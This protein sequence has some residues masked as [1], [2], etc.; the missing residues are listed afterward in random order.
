M[1]RR[2]RDEP[3]GGAPRHNYTGLALAASLEATIGIEPVCRALQHRLDPAKSLGIRALSHESPLPPA[4]EPVATMA[5]NVRTVRHA[6]RDQL[7]LMPPSVPDCCQRI[8][9]PDSCTPPWWLA[10]I[11]RPGSRFATPPS[12]HP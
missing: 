8:I 6:E 5:I 11:T 12:G 9:W 3:G 4:I 10:P 2:I 7:W 1:S